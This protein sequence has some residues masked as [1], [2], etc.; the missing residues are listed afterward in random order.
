MK[1]YIY[2]IINNITNQRYVG[3]TTNFTRR[4]AEHLLKLREN[5]HPNIKLQNAYNKYG[6]DN[7]TIQ[8][9]TI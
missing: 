7:F 1:C 5:R 4:K 8:K 2:F 3:Q 6:L 9:N